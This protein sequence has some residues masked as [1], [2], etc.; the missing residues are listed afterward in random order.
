MYFIKM[1]SQRFNINYNKK[2]YEQKL[3]KGNIKYQKNK[4]CFEIA[5][6]NMFIKFMNWLQTR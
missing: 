1:E 4:K 6:K 3:N 2:L 5:D